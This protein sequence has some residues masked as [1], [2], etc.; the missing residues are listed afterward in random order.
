VGQEPPV[1][2]PSANGSPAR[3]RTLGSKHPSSGA[4]SVR[5][6]T[7]P[8]RVSE[9]LKGPRPAPRPPASGF[10][11]YLPLTPSSLY[12]PCVAR[13]QT[14]VARRDQTTWAQRLKRVFNIDIEPCPAF[15]GAVRITACLAGSKVIEKILTHLDAK[16]AEPKASRRP[17][18]RAPP[19]TRLFE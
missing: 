6:C 4:D 9:I 11:P 1:E 18:C 12:V 5:R 16:G 17:P 8:R 19:Q 14:P 7:E 15:G 13:K 10:D 2:A 3:L